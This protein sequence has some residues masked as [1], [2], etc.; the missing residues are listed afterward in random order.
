MNRAYSLMG[1]FLAI[2]LLAS[3]GCTDTGTVMCASGVRCPSGLVCVE[4]YGQ[5]GEPEQVAACDGKAEGASCDFGQDTGGV[6]FRG[7]CAVAVC[8]NGRVDPGESCD[9]G[10]EVAGDGCSADCGSTEV[11]GNGVI[12]QDLG[13]ACDCGD[14]SQAIALPSM[15]EGRANA[16]TGVCRTDCTLHCGDGEINAEEECDT[17]APN[18]LYCVDRGFDFGRPSCSNSCAVT[19]AGCHLLG[20]SAMRAPEFADVIAVWGTDK[21]DIFA[22]GETVGAMGRSA[23]WHYDGFVWKEAV[24]D[25]GERLNAVWGLGSRDVYAVGD[26]GAIWHFTDQGWAREPNPPG[27]SALHGVW[28][29]AADDVYAVG[30]GGAIWHYDGTSW[31]DQSP[32]PVS[33]TLTA[34]WGTGE[35]EVYAVGLD[36][37]ALRYDGAGWAPVSGLVTTASFHAIWGQD[38]ENIYVVGKNEDEGPDAGSIW[39]L[40]GGTWSETL[41]APEMSSVFGVGASSVFA[42]GDGGATL[43]FDGAT[44]A[45]IG[46]PTSTA[47]NGIWG[48]GPENIVAVGF[49]STVL[50]YA[51]SRLVG[52]PGLSAS[53]TIEGVWGTGPDNIFVADKSYNIFRYDGTD[54]TAMTL[55][56]VGSPGDVIPIDPSLPTNPLPRAHFDGGGAVI[57]APRPGDPAYL[58][59]APREV[60]LSDIWGSDSSNVFATGYGVILHFNGSGSWTEMTIPHAAPFAALWGNAGDDVFAGGSST[61]LR[62]NG[63]SWVRQIAP[64]G[65]NVRGLWSDGSHHYAVGAM[66]DEILH[67]S[68]SGWEFEVVP[69]TAVL[70][71]VWGSGPDHVV[72]VGEAGT[73]LHYREGEWTKVQDVPTFLSLRR[74]WGTASDDIFAVGD[75]GTLIHY[76]GQ[77]WSPIRSNTQVELRAIWK[78]GPSGVV[79]AGKSGEAQILSRTAISTQ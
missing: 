49:G 11:C 18:E 10:N 50:Q 64:T 79:F 66:G 24:M 26:G 71:S 54:W 23:V 17:N 30:E 60:T 38:S 70:N 63:A 59:K 62:W 45:D 16:A 2:G 5:C 41:V 39:R 44:W 43:Y 40:E 1:V 61:I 75:A 14:G 9:D 51:G 19:L 53:V 74:V 28:G 27:S 32:T 37:T 52:L 73:I 20:W 55:P 25:G 13:E 7:V 72:A 78:A 69:S 3:T 6:C 47:L 76:D 58:P 22:V 57:I 48:S 77:V 34:V 15:C 4:Q 56:D 8:G 67:D 31:Q 33:P 12:D 35:S 65:T 68:G 21:N 36:G 46:S 29:S 42:V